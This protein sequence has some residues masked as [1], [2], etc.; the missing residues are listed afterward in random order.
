MSSQKSLFPKLNLEALEKFSAKAAKVLADYS[1][2]RIS[3][4]E[5]DKCDP[6]QDEEGT[7]IKN[8]PW[9]NENANYA[10]VFT[11][12]DNDSQQRLAV[13]LSLINLQKGYEAFLPFNLEKELKRCYEFEPNGR[14]LKEWCF[15]SMAEEEN[16]LPTGIKKN[17]TWVLY[18]SKESP[19]ADEFIKSL[20]IEVENNSEITI[21]TP[22]R[23]AKTYH[24]TAMGFKNERVNTWWLLLDTL[25]K[26]PH[27]IELPKGHKRE[28]EKKWKTLNRLNEKLIQ[29][30][31]KE[32]NINFPKNYKIHKRYSLEEYHS[33]ILKFKPPVFKTRV[34]RGYQGMSKE[35]LI[36]EIQY[37]AENR[38]KSK[39]DEKRSQ[40]NER[41]TEALKVA[42]DKGY[43][44]KEWVKEDLLE[45]MKDIEESV[46]EEFE[47]AQSK[48][49][50]HR[51][52]SNSTL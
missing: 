11:V 10:L 42:V 13:I 24:C 41:L 48:P 1:V 35:E 46:L 28:Y 43:V 8:L 39:A 26:P 5:Y 34:M 31:Q 3:L 16:E 29:F 17:P 2:R 4:Y 52:T 25:R 14:V 45:S 50:S 12:Q 19:P 49:A 30:F 23:A 33:F 20:K 40:I 22:G 7:P 21:R 51:L 47:E 9:H 44:T 36:Q 6:G 18:E 38:R 32:Y 37:L 27:I 15:F